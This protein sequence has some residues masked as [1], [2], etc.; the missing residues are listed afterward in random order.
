MLTAVGGFDNTTEKIFPRIIH[1]KC[2]LTT[3]RYL[4]SSLKTET[5][6]KRGRKYPYEKFYGARKNLQPNLVRNVE[7]CDFETE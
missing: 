3:F 7:A 2:I 6:D 5:S 4:S 1:P